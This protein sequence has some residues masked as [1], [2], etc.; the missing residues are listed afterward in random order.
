MIHYYSGC[1]PIRFIYFWWSLK[2]VSIKV[3][4]W[5]IIN[6]VMWVRSWSWFKRFHKVNKLLINI[7][8][9]DHLHTLF[10]Q[11]SINW[12]NMFI[13]R[14]QFL[15]T[16]TDALFF[17]QKYTIQCVCEQCGSSLLI[18]LNYLYTVQSSVITGLLTIKRLG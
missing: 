1:D 14:F 12:P 8:Q 3:Q 4:N 5:S 11:L 9:R 15:Y 16:P 2:Y 13:H 6:Y 18:S 10:Y 7:T 17:A